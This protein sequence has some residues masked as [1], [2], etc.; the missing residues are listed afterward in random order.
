MSWFCVSS[1][2]DLNDALWYCYC[3]G[4]VIILR[5]HCDIVVS[6]TYIVVCLQFIKI[7]FIQFFLSI[8]V[9]FS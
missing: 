1:L 3:P 9:L 7:L 4:L 5:G 2:N 6:V 8:S